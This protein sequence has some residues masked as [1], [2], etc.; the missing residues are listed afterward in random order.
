M[1]GVNATDAESLTLVVGNGTDSGYELRAAVAPADDGAILRFDH[2]AAGDGDGDVLTAVGCADVTVESETDLDA[3]LDAG[4]YELRL[5]DVDG[6]V[7]DVGSVVV[8][9]ASDADGADDEASS[10]GP[11]SRET[12]DDAD[13]VVRPETDR[14]IA[15]PTVADDGDEVIAR[16]RSTGQTDPSFIMTEEATVADGTAVAT[17]DLSAVPHGATATA[18]ARSDGNDGTETTVLVIDPN[19]GI[20]GDVTLADVETRGDAVD[21]DEAADDESDSD[22]GGASTGEPDLHGDSEEDLDGTDDEVPGFG[23]ALTTLAVLA[24]ALLATRH[25]NIIGTD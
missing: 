25:Q 16:L 19:V 2:A 1:I 8:E 9:S 17:F 14:E 13:A 20:E 10:P 12:V 24:M 22:D 7:V 11:V 3:A 4:T 21:G 23:V 5:L 18:T 6:D 15:V